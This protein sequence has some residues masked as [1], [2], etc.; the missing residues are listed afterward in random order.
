M[1]NPE[2]PA[3]TSV[4]AAGQALRRLAIVAVAIVLVAAVAAGFALAFRGSL[5]AVVKALGG[6]N[7]VVMIANLPLWARVLLP[8]AGGLGAGLI[9]LWSA[10]QRGASGVGFVMEAIVLGRARVP[11]MRSV[12][13]AIASWLAIATG[14]SLG[15]EG[16]LIQ[17]GA[18]AGEGARRWLKLDDAQARLV[19]AAGVAA[20]FASAYNAPIAATLFVVE[21]VT[22]VVALE[23]TV[24]VVIASVLATVIMRLA[25]S[26][27][28]LYGFRGIA[29]PD[30]V[31][32]A[33]FAGLGVC[34]APLG[35]G[36]L[37][38]V[39]RAE[40]GWRK[41]PLPWRPAAGGAVCGACLCALPALAG[42]GFEEVSAMLDGRIAIA[43]VAWL[44]LAKP[45]ATAASVGSGNPGGVF[46]PTL[47]L[48]ACTGA[49]YAAG[50]H[51]VFGSEIAPSAAYVIVGLAA[52]L[53]ATTHAPVMAAVLACELSGNWALAL[54]LL[55]ACA[56]A[57]AL[58]RRLYI[59]SVYTAELTRRGVRWRLT[60]DGRRVVEDKQ[61]NVV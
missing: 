38:I 21:V 53:A 8:A 7:V 50:L 22:G 32:L 13:Q 17:F 26:A 29:A 19:L 20:G 34:A 54:P 33:A 46:T 42:N 4:P 55:L 35:V 40:R 59:D 24:P 37:R 31:E 25:T 45:F 23:A 49:L 39:S 1:A 51:A 15:R 28:P 12:L 57:A 9:G 47:M 16:P 2:L 41:L 36:F 3:S 44:L 27:A 61:A 52:A 30:P 5:V 48:G 18:A 6:S 60:L 14:N 43:A 58:A 56:I 10:R 11:L